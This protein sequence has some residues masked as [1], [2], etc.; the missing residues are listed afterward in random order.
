MTARWGWHPFRPRSDEAI[1]LGA[2]ALALFKLQCQW[3]NAVLGVHPHIVLENSGVWHQLFSE[4]QLLASVC[5]LRQ[6]A[7]LQHQLLSFSSTAAFQRDFLPLQCFNYRNLVLPRNRE[8]ARWPQILAVLSKENWFC[9]GVSGSSYWVLAALPAGFEINVVKT[10]SSINQ[11]PIRNIFHHANHLKTEKST[12]PTIWSIWSPP[13]AIIT[14]T[15]SKQPLS[16]RSCVQS[17]LIQ[18]PPYQIKQTFPSRRLLDSYSLW[19]ISGNG[20]GNHWQ[21]AFFLQK[22]K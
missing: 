22:K 17:N 13:L 4:R 7:V 6:N 10:G 5:K 15:H 16:W 12:K 14:P 20:L 1:P 9:S 11:H 18:H 2:F 8:V 19:L 21:N 3:H